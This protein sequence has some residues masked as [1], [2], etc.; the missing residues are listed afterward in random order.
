MSTRRPS[1][2]ERPNRSSGLSGPLVASPSGSSRPGP[3]RQRTLNR[4]S[5]GCPGS[6]LEPSRRR[7]GAALPG[8][9]NEL[10]ETSGNAL[11]PRRHDLRAR[12]HGL[13]GG[14]RPGQPARS[15]HRLRPGRTRRLRGPVAV[16]RAPG[17]AAATARGQG[18]LL[19]LGRLRDAEA[20]LVQPVARHVGR[21]QG[22]LHERLGH[23]RPA[24]RM[25]R[26]LELRRAE[27]P[28]LGG[29]TP[30]GATRRAWS[31]STAST[32]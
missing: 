13:A 2:W 5:P 1:G 9:P 3:R 12:R 6:S 21:G 16:Q 15:R 30:A 14:R 11:A 26:G 22:R 28:Q 23:R 31:E 20:G 8:G 4:T 24:R 32:G 29:D 17:R 10:G 18:R 19:K 7:W 25:G 27:V